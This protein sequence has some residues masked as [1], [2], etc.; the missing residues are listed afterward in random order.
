[1]T[2]PHTPAQETKGIE[3]YDAGAMVLPMLVCEIVRSLGLKKSHMST[4]TYDF[5]MRMVD[6][7]N[8][9]VELIQEFMNKYPSA[10]TYADQFFKQIRDME[11]A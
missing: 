10:R 3:R 1:M 6:E 7:D 2:N 8:S 4:K 5:L 11:T 9:S